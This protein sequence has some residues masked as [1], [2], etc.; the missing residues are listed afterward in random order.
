MVALGADTPEVDPELLQGFLIETA[1][2]LESIEVGAL[3]LEGCQDRETLQGLFRSFHTIK[4]LAGF[5][6]RR[7]IQRIAHAT[8]SLMSACL[9]EGV[10][11]ERGVVDAIL[12]SSDLIRRLCAESSLAGEE[13]FLA[14]AERHLA[15]VERLARPRPEGTDEP[16]PREAEPPAPP[17][18]AAGGEFRPV[19]LDG[20][21]LDAGFVAESLKDF[22]AETCDS[23]ASA[24]TALIDLESSP[25]PE[26]IDAILRAFHSVKGGARL[27][28]SFGDSMGG[29]LAHFREIEAI[30]HDLE[31]IFH[32]IQSGRAPVD[33]GVIDAALAGV[34]WLKSVEG[35]LETRAALPDAADLRSRLGGIL[36][37]RP[38]SA[39]SAGEPLPPA[40][41]SAP[42]PSLSPAARNLM[43][44]LLEYLR[45]V[46]FGAI[47]AQQLSRMERGLRKALAAS[48]GAIAGALDRLDRALAGGDEG[49]FAEAR[50][51]LEG[52][53]VGAEAPPAPTPGASP[54]EGI[55]AGSAAPERQ[56]P[57]SEAP[58][59][60][61]PEGTPRPA[62][63]PR[64][65]SASI[66]VDREKVD[67]LLNLVGE[68]LTLKNS[69]GHLVRT[70][71]GESSR[72]ANELR[73]RNAEL[74]R[75][76][77]EFQG[78]VLSM[79]MV[80]VETLFARYRRVVR[81]LSA[82]L[83]KEV[84]LAIEGGETE[85][86]RVVLEKLADPL[87]HIVRNAADHGIESPEVR[88]AAGKPAR[89]RVTLR[90]YYRG[91][92]VFVEASD[93]GAGMDPDRIRAKAAERGLLTPEEALARDDGRILEC[94]FEPG[95]STA[96]RVTSISGRGVGMEV[97][98][99]NVEAVGG[100][101]FVSSHL[102]RGTTFTMR[103]PLSVSSIKGLR[104]RIGEQTYVFPLDSVEETLK[105][106]RDAVREFPGFR[107]ARVRGAS[108]PLVS[109]REVLEGVPVDL[110]SEAY[111]FDLIP[112]VVLRDEAGRVALAVDRMVEESEYLVKP[113]PEALQFGAA[114]GATILGDGSLSLILNPSGMVA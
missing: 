44:Q 111:E 46:P 47:R 36:R 43:D 11:V 19:V 4:G 110:A 69:F 78:M 16:A 54:G 49:A 99:T 72:L 57:P 98:R 42:A 48:D 63:A 100:R 74:A 32:Q 8:E 23:L 20:F 71:E 104:V 41:A 75:L 108:L 101:V 37:R 59:R 34:D 97:V 62:A 27:M 29:L 31:E 95:F 40:P 93:D 45:S 30:A 67:K 103:I 18:P 96:D 35:C 5:V 73:G 77:A 15:E 3:D 26:R 21:E 114:I 2:H 51:L 39:P 89:G 61:E 6:E 81:D 14:D 10:P 88:A 24:E 102:G 70:A 64:I 55:G 76:V 9:V 33:R 17:E 1:E 112:V 82:E 90:A 13:R 92:F 7:L 94:V 68:L 58:A 91:S 83:G 52:R 86:D 53:L 12:G 106:P 66:R 109:A 113:L 79:R 65:D 50:A 60:S 85:L 28:L 56:A 107:L 25:E 84:E 105:I 38:D 22:Q 80:R 87:T